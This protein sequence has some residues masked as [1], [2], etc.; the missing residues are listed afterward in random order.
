MEIEKMLGDDKGNYP[1]RDQRK[2]KRGEKLSRISGI[3]YSYIRP[4][5]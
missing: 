3:V 1:E 5:L 2:K 4:R